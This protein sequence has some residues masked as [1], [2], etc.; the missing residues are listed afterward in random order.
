MEYRFLG[1]T[2][3]RISELVLGTMAFGGDADKSTSSKLFE[4]AYDAGI[5]CFD[6]AD[7]YAGGRSEE[8]LGKFIRKRRDQVVIATKGYFPS[9]DGPNDRGTSRYHLVRAVEASLKRLNTDYIDIY[10]LHRFDDETRID[11]TLRVLDDLVR[12]GKI[13]YPAASNFAAWQVAKA[14]GLQQMKGYEP[15]AAIQ[16]MYNLAKRQAEVEILPQAQAEGIAVLPYSPLG[17]GLLTGKYDASKKPESGRLIDSKM[18]QVR[19][20]NEEYYELAGKFCALADKWGYHP[21]SL[22]IA[23]VASHPA[24]TAP[25]IGARNLEQLEMCLKSTEI[26]LSCEMRDEISALSVAPPPATDR[27]EES[28]AHNFGA[29]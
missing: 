19:Y 1:H 18:Y 27:N 5:N 7:V 15:F 26:E 25:L 21:A 23:W 10:F 13:L 20:A 14:L 2:G 8:L 28:S 11:E 4:R 29:R 22:A 24:V 3:V 6:C 12:Q 17:A 16:P 9:G